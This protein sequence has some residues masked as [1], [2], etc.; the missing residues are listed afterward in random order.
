MPTRRP[1]RS[2]A[3][4]CCSGSSGSGNGCGPGG[5]AR[6]EACHCPAGTPSGAAVI[7]PL[8][9]PEALVEPVE[10]IGGKAAGLAR[11]FALGLP[12]PP[13]AAVPADAAGS[14]PDDHDV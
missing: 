7:I 12:V 2:T 14:G 8:D 11:L 1:G 6:R 5:R 13:A 10:R 9:T 3:A 4:G